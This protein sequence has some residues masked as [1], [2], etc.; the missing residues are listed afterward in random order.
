MAAIKQIT[1]K[2]RA[3]TTGLGLAAFG[4]SGQW[5]V[6]LDESTSAPARWFL[7][8]EGPNVSIRIGLRSLDAFNKALTFLSGRL[9]LRKNGSAVKEA[10]VSLG[11]DDKNPV[12]LV[13]DDEL[14]DRCFLVI[15]P[16]DDPTV[17]LTLAGT[18]LV[19]VAEA[20][21]IARGDLDE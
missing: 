11:R 5:E 15:G 7:Q 9:L 21:R 3:G 12:T 6:S 10:S 19:N 4:A 20:L 16:R 18:D 13:G 14:P 2:P 1:G 17:H 8:I